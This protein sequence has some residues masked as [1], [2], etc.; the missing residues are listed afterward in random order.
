M[1]LLGYEG[2]IPQNV[3]IQE[4]ENEVALELNTPYLLPYKEFTQTLESLVKNYKSSHEEPLIWITFDDP[5][6]TKR[7]YTCAPFYLQVFL[8][9]PYLSIESILSRDQIETTIKKKFDFIVR[10]IIQRELEKN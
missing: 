8:N 6:S 4:D 9:I 2:E 3:Y 10:F 7:T 5:S 1:H